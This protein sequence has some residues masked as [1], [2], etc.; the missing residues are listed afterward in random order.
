MKEFETPTIEVVN[1]NSLE[2]LSESYMFPLM[3]FNI[4]DTFDIVNL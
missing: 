3:P 1:L 2:V 4:P